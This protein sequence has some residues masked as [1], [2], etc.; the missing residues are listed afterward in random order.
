MSRYKKLL[1]NTAL[2]A[3]GDLGSKLILIILLPLYTRYLST[4][5]YGNIEIITTTIA[6]FLPIIT[7]GIYDAVLRFVMDKNE[8]KEA[9]FTNGIMVTSLG[10]I[11]VSLIY[12]VLRFFNILDGLLV[13]LYA[14]LVLQ[15]FQTIILQ[16]VRAIGKIKIYAINGI[17]MAVLIGFFNIIFLVKLNMGIKGFLLSMVFANIISILFV[18]TSLK[19]YRYFLINIINKQLC[20][21]MLIYCVPLIPNTLMWWIMNASNR[22]FLLFFVGATS[23][24]LFSVA[25]KIPSLLSILNSVFFQAWQ[26]SAIEEFNSKNKSYYY[27]QVFN[28]LSMVMFIGTSIILV[29]LKYAMSILVSPEFYTAWEFV[30]FMLLGVV[31]ASF[32]GFLGTNYIAAKQTKGVFKTTALGGIANIVLNLIFIPLV[33][34]IGASISIMFSFFIMWILR[35]YDT[36]QFIKMELNNKNIALNLFVISIQIFVLYLN[37]NP[38]TELVLQMLLF[39]LLLIINVSLIKILLRFMHSTKNNKYKKFQDN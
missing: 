29:I 25:S 35:V 26:L 32:S 9:V 16:F 12:P 17:L 11:I 37:M 1:S 33:G 5:E 10:S 21:N 15:A 36:K 13:F 19:I 34:T 22:Y 14:I 2:F 39:L 4:A 20:K 23:V 3:V 27:S 18:S 24:G 6:L 30:P 38:I 28:H 7:L 31:F 8:K